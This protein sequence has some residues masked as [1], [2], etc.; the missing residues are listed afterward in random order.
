MT[1]KDKILRHK[2]RFIDAMR[3]AEIDAIR[4]PHMRFTVYADSNGMPCTL[5]DVSGG[6]SFYPDCVQ[7]YDVSYQAAD[8]VLYQWRDSHGIHPYAFIR[9]NREELQSQWEAAFQTAIDR[10]DD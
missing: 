3:R 5:E 7:I 4:Y 2:R 6:N 10:M 9:D 1:L 8:D